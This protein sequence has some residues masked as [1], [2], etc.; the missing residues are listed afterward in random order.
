MKNKYTVLLGSLLMMILL[1]CQKD[2]LDKK[3]DK[4]LVTPKTLKDFQAL[5][6]DEVVLMNKTSNLSI[7]G[8]DDYYLDEEVWFNL[9]SEIE[10]N[11]YI[12]S[13]DIYGGEEEYDWGVLYQQIFYSNIVL[14]GLER[15][16][17]ELKNSAEWKNIKGQALFHRA[18]IFSSLA[19]L[20]AKPYDVQ[21]S[22]ND[23][24]IIMKLTPDIN[25]KAVRVSVEETY[26]RIINDLKEAAILL[27]LYVD[28]KSRPS[29]LAT[30]AMLS[31][32]YLNMERYDNALMYADS[33]LNEYNTLMDYNQFSTTS[34]T[35]FSRFNDEVLFQSTIS[36]SSIRSS[37]KVDTLLY[38]S[39]DNNDLR[40]KLFFNDLGKNNVRF[41]GAYTGQSLW[42]S[43]LATDEVYL[44]RSE[45]L[46]RTGRLEE[47]LADLNTLL[48]MRWETNTFKTLE[49]SNE[50]GALKL[51]LEER[52]K[53][54]VFRGLRWADLRR[55]NKDSRFSQSISRKF[56]DKLFTLF[57]NDKKYIY[58]IPNFELAEGVK[59]NERD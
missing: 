54:L 24:G 46:S 33:V 13:A 7:L 50:D 18:Y 12:W 49:A 55:L 5:L 40:R 35:P 47:A 44:I 10:R 32:V 25:V 26:S 17:D 1:A 6:D 53:E 57:P 52:R 34:A 11:A 3:P 9:G 14:E 31:R 19:D 36:S 41:K 2:F 16:S 48:K 39:F 15:Y 21:T 23:L 38:A 30:W 37:S 51:I 42:F 22:N 4:S 58:P 45:C 29:K 20:F 28:F 59:Q 8:S 43:G 56:R 27:P